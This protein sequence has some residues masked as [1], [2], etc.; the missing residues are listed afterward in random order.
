MTYRG[1]AKGKTIELDKRLPFRQGER[2]SVRVELL[3]RRRSCGSPAAIQEVMHEAPHLKPEAVDELERVIESGK[4]AVR[5]E[6]AFD[7]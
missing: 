2:V 5:S 6:G 3:A 1:T 7:E 4:L